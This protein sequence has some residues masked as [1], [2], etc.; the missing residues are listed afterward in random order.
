MKR[1]DRKLVQEALQ[2]SMISEG[3]IDSLVSLFIAPKLKR[4]VN[5]LKNSPEWKEW[6]QKLDSTRKEMEMYSDRLEA[7][8]KYYDEL[9]KNPEKYGVTAKG[10]KHM[11][12]LAIQ[13]GKYT[14]HALG[15]R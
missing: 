7:R 5:K 13:T 2:A 8:L 15:R 12:D 4:D 10:V 6:M 3:L 9:E 14:N 11:R 1:N